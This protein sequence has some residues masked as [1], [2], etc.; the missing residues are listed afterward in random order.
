MPIRTI[1]RTAAACVVT[2]L[3]IATAAHAQIV[4]AV[5]ERALGM[6]GAFVAVANDSSA[7]W[8]N[9]AGQAAGPFVDL[10]LG[11]AVTERRD[12]FPSGRDR[13][14]GFALSTPVI[15]A[16]V[17]RLIA[18]DAGPDST[19]SLAGG[20]QDEEVPRTLRAWSATSVG[21]TI[22]QTVL[23]GTHVGATVKYVRGTVR[24]GVAIPG[25]GPDAAL[26]D[27]GSLEGGK[28]EGRLDFD[29][30][31]LAT[32]GPVRLG[33]L[34]RN[35][36]EAEFGD[37][38]FK[39]PRQA[40]FGAAVALEDA[41]GPPLTLA[42]DVDLR[43]YVA[44]GERRRVVAVGGEH[45]FAARRLGIRGGARFN[46]AGEVERALTAGVSVALRAGSYLEA[47]VVGGGTP[48]EQGW[49]TGVRVS[50]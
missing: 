1:I 21:A 28:A 45:W 34:V 41:G 6:G 50:F 8:W 3:A 40:R 20:R 32:A 49:G 19:E 17:W 37:G 9:P 14:S 11:R 31:A 29:I 13:V 24:S 5:G 33:L 25:H 12:A 4:E 30:G 18:H 15:G 46:T 36:R 23:D 16:H 10:S 27:A 26:D 44:D 2:S 7:A 38:S 42:V 43:A 39:L 48:A 22:V 35:V 47:H